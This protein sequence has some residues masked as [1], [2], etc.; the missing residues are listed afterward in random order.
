M[1]FFCSCVL[2]Y[3][4]LPLKS[5]DIPKQWL[6]ASSQYS[7]LSCYVFLFQV[8][9]GFLSPV[10][11]LD[12]NFRGVHFMI[13]EL[14]RKRK[15]GSEMLEAK[16]ENINT[17]ITLFFVIKYKLVLSHNKILKFRALRRS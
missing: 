6:M 10:D 13:S 5:C 1:L 12:I 3:L 14:G 9:L 16:L 7:S 17:D 4:G 2:N 8:F 11:M 15:G